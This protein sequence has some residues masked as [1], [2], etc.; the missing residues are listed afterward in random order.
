MRTELKILV[1]DRGYILVALIREH[2]TDYTQWLAEKKAIIRVWG[3]TEGLGEL[4]RKGPLKDTKL[5]EEPEGEISK[6][7]TLRTMLCDSKA[8]KKWIDS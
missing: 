6:M 5:D 4:A 2:P 8:W 7:H 1:M 3:T